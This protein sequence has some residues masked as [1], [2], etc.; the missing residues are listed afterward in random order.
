MQEEEEEN[1]SGFACSRIDTNRELFQ[2][3][4]P[5]SPLTRRLFHHSPRTRSILSLTG[6]VIWPANVRWASH[7]RR[8]A[9]LRASFAI[10]DQVLPFV[11]KPSFSHETYAS[12]RFLFSKGV[13]AAVLRTDNDIPPDSLKQ[14]S[15]YS[16]ARFSGND[17]NR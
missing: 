9:A 15:H 12:D 2:R 5:S 16:V 10:E 6:L 3:R 14:A 11:S 8:S 7:Q 1:F 4:H 13:H 17:G